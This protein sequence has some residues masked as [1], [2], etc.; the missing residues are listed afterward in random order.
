M[1]VIPKMKPEMIMMNNNKMS[2][3]KRFYNILGLA[4]FFGALVSCNKA[5]MDTNTS[6][7]N[8]VFK[9][10]FEQ[11]AAEAK[12]VL[13]GT[14]NHDVLWVKGDAIKIWDNAKLSG[15]YT[16]SQA[17]GTSYF[18]VINAE[19]GF[20]DENAEYAFYPA[21][22]VNGID[23][24]VI[25]FTIPAN[26]TYAENSFGADANFAVSKVVKEKSGGR[27]IH[28]LNFTNVAGALRIQLTCDPSTTPVSVSKIVLKDKS[29]NICG[30]FSVDA[31]GEKPAAQY[32]ENGGKKI[33]LNCPT[34]VALSTD[35]NNPTS[36]YITLPVGAIA[37]NSGFVAEVYNAYGHLVTVLKASNK[38]GK[39]TIKRSN[40]TWMKNK[41]F[42]WIPKEVTE[43]TYLQSH[44]MEGTFVPDLGKTVYK[45]QFINTGVNPVNGIRVQMKGSMDSQAA[46]D[47]YGNPSF[48]GLIDPS[49]ESTWSPW[50]SI[51][52]HTG[53][54]G[55]RASLN[56]RNHFSDPKVTI[57]TIAEY[58]INFFPGNNNF[59][60]SVN[61]SEFTDTYGHPELGM[62]NQT[63]FFIFA[64]G[65]LNTALT[66]GDGK[67]DANGTRFAE[68]RGI[69]SIY[70][71][72]IY[73]R[74]DKMIRN[75]VP[76][77]Y[78]GKNGMWDAV[79]GNFYGP[80]TNRFCSGEFILG[81]TEL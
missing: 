7:Y 29:Q 74:N 8:A 59:T 78:N 41:N 81:K 32:V 36:F 50:I 38:D 26:Q 57:G 44:L 63:N 16:A 43:A 55:V 66:P 15:T 17:G 46:A 75:F 77:Q 68:N 48:C 12:T 49:A 13:G 35:P 72:V 80:C 73:D 3:M 51:D 67:E 19:E 37:Q 31:S 34:P 79:N 4:M 25:S 62:P 40:I 2:N 9:A 69:C 60:G 23:G 39:A 28:V 65:R 76:A 14:D 5:D 56:G 54:A 18:N 10:S 70:M 6:K 21:N 64:E 24:D 58:D 11:P 71:F 27:D 45:S 42:P 53:V 52:Y 1:K 33:T 20:I 47:G 61:G 30:T 22:A